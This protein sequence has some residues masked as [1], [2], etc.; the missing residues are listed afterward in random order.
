MK[1]CKSCGAAM[2]DSALVCPACSVSAGPSQPNS[3]QANYSN[4]QYSS[5]QQQGN[6]NQQQ[7]SSNQQQGNPNQQQYNSNQQYYNPNQQNSNSA[8]FNFN[9]GADYSGNYH[10][11]DIQENKV[12]A[13]LA[14]CWILFFL[15]LVVCPNSQYGKFHANQGLIVLI[16]SAAG[17][18]VSALISNLFGLIPVIGV[19]FSIIGGLLAT[20]V[21][22]A[23]FVLV[24]IGI[25]NVVN[26]N[27][28]DL[29]IIGKFRILK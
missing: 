22:I 14:Y 13:A 5:N 17:S 16:F 23:S 3:G 15:P 1:Y 24:V 7:Y 6:P 18:I 19:I 2:D 11:A 29:P 26:G 28:K 25:V 12:W 27:A 4:Q 8:S 20:A 10:P 9:N 21:S